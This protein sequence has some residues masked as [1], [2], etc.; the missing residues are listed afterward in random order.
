MLTPDESR[1]SLAEEN[2]EA[3][4]PD[5]FEEAYIGVARRCGKPT[6]GAFSVQKA[7]EILRKRDGMS[8]EEEV[9]YFEFNVVGAWMGEGTPIWIEDHPL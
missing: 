4:W 8:Y 7:L 5:G 2:P 9:D 3:L 6:L 1:M